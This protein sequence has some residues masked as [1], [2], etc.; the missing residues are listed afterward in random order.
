MRCLMGAFV[1]NSLKPSGILVMAAQGC[2]ARTSPERGK[3]MAVSRAVVTGLVLGG[4]LLAGG[5][6]AQVQVE[7]QVM[8]ADQGR[9]A[10]CAPYPYGRADDVHRPGYNGMLWIGR[11][12]I[13]GLNTGYPLDWNAPGPDAYGASEYDDQTVHALF[14]CQSVPLSPWEYVEGSGLHALEQARQK[15]LRERGYVGGVRTFVNDLYL[16]RDEVAATAPQARATI[17]L[18]ADQPR[19]KSRMQ[20]NASDTVTSVCVA[21]EFKDLTNARIS[22]PHNAPAAARDRSTRLAQGP[23]ASK[24]E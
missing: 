8:S 5:V 18:P 3:D 21:P 23:Q 4:A 2:A 1:L 11:P 14:G 22:W 16:Y 12:I 10:S 17:E 19:F 9:L 13:G 7:K 20:V 6:E 24:A 15:W